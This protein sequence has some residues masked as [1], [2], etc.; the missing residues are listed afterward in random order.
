[1]TLSLI[2]WT[3]ICCKYLLD[4]SPL[5]KQ[6][7]FQAATAGFWKYRSWVYGR[8]GVHRVKHWSEVNT[9]FQKGGWGIVW[10]TVHTP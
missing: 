1:M 6:L 10:I 7:F 3:L 5:E 2:H 9:G 8:I 4:G